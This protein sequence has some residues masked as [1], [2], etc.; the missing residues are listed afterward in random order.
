MY[1]CIVVIGD[2]VQGF[3]LFVLGVSFVLLV[4][5]F[6]LGVGILFVGFFVVVVF[7]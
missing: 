4:A 2:F 6:C 5:W 1:V 3:F 7:V